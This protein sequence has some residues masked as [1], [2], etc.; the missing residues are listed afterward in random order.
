MKRDNEAL[1]GIILLAMLLIA[2]IALVV[3]VVLIF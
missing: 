2:V 3:A 1:E